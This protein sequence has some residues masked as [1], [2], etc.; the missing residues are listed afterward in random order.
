MKVSKKVESKFVR[1]SEAA[2][3]QPRANVKI[4]ITAMID[5]DVIDR[6]REISRETGARYQTLLNAK[7]RESVLNETVMD[8]NAM[9]VINEKIDKLERQV[10]QLSRR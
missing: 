4:R 6:L 3:K 2:L 10:D 5:A 9:D 7:L 1:D 8:K